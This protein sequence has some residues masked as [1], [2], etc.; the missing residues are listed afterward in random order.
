MHWADPSLSPLN[1]HT[2][3]ALRTSLYTLPKQ[4]QA[5]DFCQAGS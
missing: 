3:A 4:Q 5:E 1:P 2:V